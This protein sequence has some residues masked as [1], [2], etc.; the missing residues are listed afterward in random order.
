MLFFVGFILPMKEF[1]H[2]ELLT[3]SPIKPFV[4]CRAFVKNVLY[5]HSS[6]LNEIFKKPCLIFKKVALT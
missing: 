6:F 4:V 5:D 3:N 1:Y 2:Y